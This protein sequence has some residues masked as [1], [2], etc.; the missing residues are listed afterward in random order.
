M[1]PLGGEFG[2]TRTV[3]VVGAAELRAGLDRNDHGFSVVIAGKG[4][5]LGVRYG[6]A[7]EFGH[8]VAANPVHVHD[9]DATMPPRRGLGPSASRIALAVEASA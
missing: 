8:K 3:A 6:T 5:R 7:D 9:L 1:V 2:R 4:L